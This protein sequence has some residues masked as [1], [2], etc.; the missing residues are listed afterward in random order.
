MITKDIH[1]PGLQPMALKF[2]V[3]YLRYRWHRE[4]GFR[5]SK[6]RIRRQLGKLKTKR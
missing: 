4:W 2:S 1:R 6:R 5:P 3:S